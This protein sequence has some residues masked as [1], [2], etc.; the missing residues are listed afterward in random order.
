MTRTIGKIGPHS[1][2]LDELDFR[3]DV[4]AG[5]V[6]SVANQVG[7]TSQVGLSATTPVLTL[8]NPMGS[9]IKGRLHFAGAVFT[10]AFGTAGA[11]FLAV[12]TN[13]A[14]LAVTGTVTTAHRR[15]R[16]GGITSQGNTIQAFLAATLPAAPVAISLLGVGLTGAITTVPHLQPLGRWYNGAI[17]IMPGTNLSI[18]TGVASG[19]SGMLCEYLWEELPLTATPGIS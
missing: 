2:D 14:S 16:L 3:D 17:E 8:A 1:V 4:A 18:Q 12:G 7:V 11:V 19:A 10:V 5:H 6:Y 15:T 13:V 9:G